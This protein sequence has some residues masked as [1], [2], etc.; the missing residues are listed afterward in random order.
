MVKRRLAVLAS[1]LLALTFAVSVSACGGDDEASDDLLAAI[2]ERGVLNV[3]TDPAYPPA[4]SLNEKTGKYEGFDIDVATE[5][6]TRLGVDVA[7]KDKAWDLITAGNW[8][9]RWDISVGSM[10]ITPERSEV[11]HFSPPYYYTPAV[12]AV[13]NDNTSITDVAGLDGKSI[14]VG[15]ATTYDTYLQNTLSIQDED[16]NVETIES[17]VTDPNVRTYE[18]DA[19]ALEDLALGDGTRLDAAISARPIIQG[20]IDADSAIK[21]VGTA[22]YYEPLSVAIDRGS[23]LDPASLLERISEIVDELHED[24]TLTELSQKWFGTDYSVTES[25]S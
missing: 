14:G 12:I 13:H 15:V 20:A 10:T 7:F 21:I 18:T 24:G 4:S 22:L 5:I 23:Q 17:P 6:A 25:T 3:S 9:G 16:G 8:N 19:F 1:L 2:E 11:L